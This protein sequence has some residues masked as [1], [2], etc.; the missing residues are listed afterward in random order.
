[1][2]GIIGLFIAVGIII[3]ISSR[4]DVHSG[5]EF[6][7]SREDHLFTHAAAGAG[8]AASMFFLQQ[9]MEQQ[10]IN[11]EMFRQME[12]M[13]LQQMTDFAMQQQWLEQEEIQRMME[14]SMDPVINPGLDIVTDEVFHGIDHGTSDVHHHTDQLDIDTNM[15]DDLYGDDPF[16]DDNHL[17]MDD[18]FQTDHDWNSGM[19]HMDNHFHDTHHHF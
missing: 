16:F 15:H 3:T 9:I 17:D 1:M 4:R 5:P 8:G 2:L 10:H 19:D 18:H 7:S 13:N 11:E 6:E 12:Q 14:Q